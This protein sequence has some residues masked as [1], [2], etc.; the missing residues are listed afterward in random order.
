MG[1]DNHQECFLVL[2]GLRYIGDIRGAK[3]WNSWAHCEDNL[4]LHVESTVEALRWQGGEVGTQA[5]LALAKVIWECD[6]GKVTWKL[7]AEAFAYAGLEV[8]QDLQEKRRK[9]QRLWREYGLTW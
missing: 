9:L 6:P 3:A 4:D 5:A 7:L 1:F 8:S 2:E